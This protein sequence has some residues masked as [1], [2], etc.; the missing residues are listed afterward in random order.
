MVINHLLNGMILQAKL[1]PQINSRPYDQGLWKPI[2]GGT[3]DSHDIMGFK[4][5]FLSPK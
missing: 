1:P 5:L 2:G 4:M 3:L